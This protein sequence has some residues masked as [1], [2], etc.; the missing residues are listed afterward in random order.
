MQ[1]GGARTVLD[2]RCVARWEA[3]TWLAADRR[4]VHALDTF[5]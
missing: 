2:R 5:N 4:L 1:R 3:M